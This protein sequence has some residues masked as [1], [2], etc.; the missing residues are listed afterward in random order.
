MMWSRFWNWYGSNKNKIGIF[1][2]VAGF[3]IGVVS[4]VTGEFI[5][6]SLV[7]VAVGMIVLASAKNGQDK[8]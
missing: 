7:W 3:L 4:A 2:I 1:Y 5:S 6:S 8:P